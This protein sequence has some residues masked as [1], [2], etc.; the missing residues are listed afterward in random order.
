[1]YTKPKQYYTRTNLKGTGQCFSRL[2]SLLLLFSQLSREN[3]SLK[4]RS[5]MF[6]SHLSPDLVCH[7]NL[8]E[9]EEPL[10][11]QGLQEPL[12]LQEP[13]DLQEPLELQGLQDS[14]N[15]VSLFAL[16]EFEE[17]E[18]NL[19]L[20]KNL[21]T[22]AE[23]FARE[24]FVEQ[25]KLKRQSQILMQSSVPDQALSQA[26]EQVQT[27]TGD[28]ERERLEHQLQVC[29]TLLQREGLLSRLQLMEEQK[30]EAS[31]LWSKAR[32]EAKDLRFTVEELQ[33]KIQTLSN[34]VPG[35]PAPP[36]PPPPPPPP[37]APSSLNRPLPESLFCLDARVSPVDV[38]QQAVDEM[39]QRIKR[40]VQLRPV[41]QSASRS[42]RQVRDK[43]QSASR[44]GRQ[45]RIR[46]N[47]L[48]FSP[49]FLCGPRPQAF[50][51]VFLFQL[52]KKP[53]N[54][55]IQE[56]RGIMV[57][58]QIRARALPWKRITA[59]VCFLFSSG[60]L[61][62]EQPQDQRPRPVRGAGLGAQPGFTEETGRAGESA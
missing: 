6:M 58:L 2:K 50:P 39:M 1:D 35:P 16:E 38:R 15:R 34:P 14:Y 17:L 26:L 42:R 23:S 7:I 8:L 40:G 44:A 51:C 47:Q 21:R 33:K 46:T 52:E 36:P 30:E 45:V 62:P 20:E 60:Q 5:A 32:D 19:D 13:L 3:R 37:T 56:L 61:Q 41:N 31:K 48:E 57:G 24:M 27:L 10:E 25:K 12:E 43:N 18:S 49:C 59:F 9:P 29:L 4:R 28:L 22:E 11:L 55:A 53:S 54:S